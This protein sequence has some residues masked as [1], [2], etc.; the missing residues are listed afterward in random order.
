MTRNDG[1]WLLRYSKMLIDP[2]TI[3]ANGFQVKSYRQNTFL[4]SSVQV[5]G[6]RIHSNYICYVC[7]YFMIDVNQ[8]VIDLSAFYGNVRDAERSFD[9][10]KPSL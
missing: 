3:D 5:L 2:L 10:N 7:D 4:N 9:L 6:R 1:V 8:K